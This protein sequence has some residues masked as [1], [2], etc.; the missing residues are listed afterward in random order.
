[1]AVPRRVI[2]ANRNELYRYSALTFEGKAVEDLSFHVSRCDRPRSF[3][4]PVRERRLSV[5]YVSDYA[6]VSDVFHVLKNFTSREIISCCNMT[7]NYF[8]RNVQ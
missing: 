1:M 6:K 8:G 7:R 4:Q 2:H 5:I 3:E